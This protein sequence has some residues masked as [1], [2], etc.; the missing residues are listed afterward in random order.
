M[1]GPREIFFVMSHIDVWLDVIVF[2]RLG[3][4]ALGIIALG[5]VG[6]LTLYARWIYNNAYR[7][8]VKWI[9]KT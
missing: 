9:S 8:D 5:M 1:L 2:S 3:G 4:L 6:F 7:L